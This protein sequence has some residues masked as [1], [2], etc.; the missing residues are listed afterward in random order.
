MRASAS[1]GLF[2]QVDIDVD[3][4]RRAEPHHIAN[5]RDRAGAD[6]AADVVHDLMQVVRRRVG[7]GVRPQCLD[8]MITVQAMPGPVRAA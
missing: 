1:S 2:E 5:E 8:H 6:R 3:S 7:L 4:T